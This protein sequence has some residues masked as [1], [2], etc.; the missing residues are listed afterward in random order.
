MLLTAAAAILMTTAQPIQVMTFNI[1][2]GT[3][4]DGENSWPHRREDALKLI[5]SQDADIIGLQEVLQFQLEEIKQVLP[6]YTLLG[7]AREDGG[8][9]GEYAALFVKTD[10]WDIE[11]YGMFWLSDTPDV[12]GSITWDHYNTRVCTWA[13]ISRKSDGLQVRAACTHWDHESQPARE[14]SAEL[15]LKR[16]QK[17]PLI[18][19]GDFN[20]NLSNKAMKTL[21]DGGMR[22]SWLAAHPGAEEPHTFNGWQSEGWRSGKIDGIWIS[23]AFKAKSAEVLMTKGGASYPSDH[24]PVTAVLKMKKGG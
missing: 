22:D 16:L 3:A 13:D 15:I 24:F 1:R 23:P 14:K 19:M 2:Y 10:T 21:E 6:G 11:Q 17:R 5:E 7:R 20:A 4:N 8:T 12:V 18:L 9:K